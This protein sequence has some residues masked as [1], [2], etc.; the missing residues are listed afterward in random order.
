MNSVGGCLDAGS[1]SPWSVDSALC[2]V[3]WNEVGMCLANSGAVRVINSSQS[4]PSTPIRIA[5]GLPC[6][7]TTTQDFC[8]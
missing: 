6:R 2:W 5:E 8:E 4:R 7:V 3:A 1:W